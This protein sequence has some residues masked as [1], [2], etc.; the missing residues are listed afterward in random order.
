M[1]D[2]ERD[3]GE[4]AGDA[5]GDDDISRRQV[6]LVDQLRVDAGNR[7]IGLRQEIGRAVTGQVRGDAQSAAMM[8]TTIPAVTNSRRFFNN[9]KIIRQSAKT[10]RT[11]AS[12]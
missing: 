1:A 8:A 6:V 11:A 5:R 2:E 9:P 4:D 7:R 12:D 10:R 3:D